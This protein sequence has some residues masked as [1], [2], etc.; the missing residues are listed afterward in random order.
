MIVTK[1]LNGNIW[2]SD[3]I[4]GQ[5]VNRAYIGYSVRDAKRMFKQEFLDAANCDISVTTL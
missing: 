2:I 5:L 4:N 3:V 1:A